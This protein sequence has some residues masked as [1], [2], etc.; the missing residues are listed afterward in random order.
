MQVFEESREYPPLFANHMQTKFVAYKAKDYHHYPSDLIGANFRGGSQIPNPRTLHKFRPMSPLE[1]RK[2]KRKK[3]NKPASQT[4]T[5]VQVEIC[6][7]AYR[8][9]IFC[10]DYVLLDKS[11]R[12]RLNIK[13]PPSKWS[14]VYRN[15][16]LLQINEFASNPLPP[17][18][19]EFHASVEKQCKE[20]QNFLRNQWIEECV[21]ILIKHRKIDWEPLVSRKLD[22]SC[23]KIER[24]FTSFAT[25]MSTMLRI[26]YKIHIQLDGVGNDISQ[27]K[28]IQFANF[29]ILTI[30]V[31]VKDNKID[32]E[33]TCAEW[34]NEIQSVIYK[35]LCI[36]ENMPRAD[37]ILLTILED[38]KV[39]FISCSS[40]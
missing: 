30:R 17:C 31:I 10:V 25:L 32:F 5:E 34:E 16:E 35:L 29:P 22:G 13:R 8:I 23:E 37:K 38:E 39:E 24:Y 27:M 21:Q 6:A 18:I 26:D 12:Q 11:E 40:Q 20:A 19:E 33:M 9:F 28:E 1:Q 2:L 14:Y 7:N 3:L 15:R 36:S 4:D